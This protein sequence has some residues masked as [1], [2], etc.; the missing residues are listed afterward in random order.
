VTSVRWRF[1][2]TANGRDIVAE[3][4]LA[5]GIDARAAVLERAGP[6]IRG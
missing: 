3:E 2:R 5:L 4:L 1:H 6:P